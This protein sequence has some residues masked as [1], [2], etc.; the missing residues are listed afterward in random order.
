MN[1]T[2]GPH[3]DADTFD[4]LDDALAE[5]ATRRGSGSATNWP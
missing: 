5:L 3:S 4:V 1:T 2:P